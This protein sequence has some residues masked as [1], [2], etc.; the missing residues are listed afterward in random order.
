MAL[1]V[2]SADQTPDNAVIVLDVL[3]AT[4]DLI[5]NNRSLVDEMVNHMMV[6]ITTTSL[7][8]CF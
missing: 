8:D 1:A 6:N 5:G 4:A 2:Q 3:L 7:T